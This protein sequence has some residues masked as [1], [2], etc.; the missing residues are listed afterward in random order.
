MN[1]QGTKHQKSRL[2]ILGKHWDSANNCRKSYKAKYY[3]ILWILGKI[4][5]VCCH[6]NV[7]FMII[8][9][10]LSVKYLG[11][12]KI[13]FEYIEALKELWNLDDFMSLIETGGQIATQ[14]KVLSGLCREMHRNEDALL[15]L[16]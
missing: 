6:R 3:Q 7:L 12:K 8:N 16:T 5:L 10:C 11:S 1:H 13:M 9:H 4:T 15:S 14:S 2:S